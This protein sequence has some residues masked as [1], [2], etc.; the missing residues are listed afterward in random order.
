[1]QPAVSNSGSQPLH[2]KI[3]REVLNNDFE[4][5][6]FVNLVDF[7][8]AYGHRNDVDGYAKALT[9]FD[10]QLSVLIEALGDEDI[11]IVTADHGCDPST[12]STDHSREYTPM[13]IYGDC[14]VSGVDLGTRASFA[15]ISATIL[16]YFNVN[17]KYTCGISFLHDVLK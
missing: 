11:L 3:T 4:G 9:E 2:V 14:I 17:K 15:D 16:E 12:P 6:C 1:M 10:S 13:L 7:D 5:L 8:S